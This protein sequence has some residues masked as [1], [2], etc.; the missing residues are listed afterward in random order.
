MDIVF[1]QMRNAGIHT[2]SQMKAIRCATLAL[3]AE[4]PIVHF[5]TPNHAIFNKI[6]QMQIV[7]FGISEMSL[8]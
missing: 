8:F 3:I 2:K 4:S 7:L 1:T 6:V 5:T